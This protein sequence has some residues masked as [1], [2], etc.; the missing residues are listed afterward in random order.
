[1][2]TF[3]SA[4]VVR[5]VVVRPVGLAL[6]GLIRFVEVVVVVLRA[7]AVTLVRIILV[8]AILRPMSVVAVRA[9]AVG[10]LVTISS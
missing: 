5:P 7:G 3:R 4:V 9:S 2:P 1:M 10:L 8:R 6:V